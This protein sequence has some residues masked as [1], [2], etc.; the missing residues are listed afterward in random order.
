MNGGMSQAANMKRIVACSLL[1]VAVI[2]ASA[3]GARAGDLPDFSTPTMEPDWFAVC[4]GMPNYMTE[5]AEF[6]RAEKAGS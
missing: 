2:F 6:A 4:K 3:P 5:P 1:I